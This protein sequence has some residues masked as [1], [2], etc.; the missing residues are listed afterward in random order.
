MVSNEGE[1]RKE[2]PL[3]AYITDIEEEDDVSID[4]IFDIEG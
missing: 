4:D 1:D 3:D 2:D